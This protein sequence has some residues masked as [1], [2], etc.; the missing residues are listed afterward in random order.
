MYYDA[1]SET[2]VNLWFDQIRVQCGH[3]VVREGKQVNIKPSAFTLGITGS[4]QR[5]LN[6]FPIIV[7]DSQGPDCPADTS[8]SHLQS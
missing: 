8:S 6:I 7:R 1:F 5:F 2:Q 3:P 4:H